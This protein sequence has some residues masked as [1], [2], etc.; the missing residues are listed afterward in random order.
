[1]NACFEHDAT[2][3]PHF[4]ELPLSR[5]YGPVIRT[6]DGS[7]RGQCL[8][9]GA[10]FSTLN[11][12]RRHHAASHGGEAA[13][14]ACSICSR[15]YKNEASLKEHLRFKHGIYQSNLPKR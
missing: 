7:G 15:E 9:C 11:S 12:A 5:L 1:M 13:R 6:R 4:A 2:P 8:V 14:M 10:L 3:P